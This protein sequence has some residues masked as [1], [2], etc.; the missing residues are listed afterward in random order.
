MLCGKIVWNA[1]QLCCLDSIMIF[2]VMSVMQIAIL[3]NKS[4]LFH[5]QQ[6]HV[7]IFATETVLQNA[8][9]YYCLS[10]S[11]LDLME[12]P[13]QTTNVSQRRHFKFGGGT[14]PY[15]V[16]SKLPCAEASVWAQCALSLGVVL[17]SFTLTPPAEIWQIQPCTHVFYP[18]A[19]K[20]IEL[21]QEIGRRFTI[22]T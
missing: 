5:S 13:L 12:Y 2:F 1:E 3:C 7:I 19:V 10:I 8:P 14:L 22:V 20:A 21:V 11:V 18:I 16:G 15:G 4:C 9:F 17:P 6:P